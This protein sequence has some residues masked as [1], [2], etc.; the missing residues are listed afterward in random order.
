MEVLDAAQDASG[1]HRAIFDAKDKGNREVEV[2][3]SAVAP[4][5][6]PFARRER[7]RSVGSSGACEGCRARLRSLAR[8]VEQVLHRHAQVR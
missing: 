2:G 6:V 1:G 5:R 8:H 3:P 4:R 7:R